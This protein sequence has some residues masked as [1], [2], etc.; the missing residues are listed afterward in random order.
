MTLG[1][2]IR[3]EGQLARGTGN[4][5]GDGQVELEQYKFVIRGKPYVILICF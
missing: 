5:K 2:D 4:I 1:S 3:G